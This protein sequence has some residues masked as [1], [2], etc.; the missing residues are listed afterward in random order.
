MDPKIRAKLAKNNAK[1]ESTDDDD[2]DLSDDES[3]SS[4]KKAGAGHSSSD[5]LLSTHL[6]TTATLPQ[7]RTAPRCTCT[8]LPPPPCTDCLII[9]HMY[10]TATR[11]TSTQVHQCR[12]SGCTR[13]LTVLMYTTAAATAA[14]AAVLVVAVQ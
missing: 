11:C 6:Y 10:T 12:H 5:F 13:V 3:D 9:M 4:G 1:M 7:C 14:A 2:D 8:P